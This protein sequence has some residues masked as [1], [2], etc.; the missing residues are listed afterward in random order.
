MWSP[1]RGAGAAHGTGMNPVPVN[2]APSAQLGELLLEHWCTCSSCSSWVSHLQVL[3]CSVN[4]QRLSFLLK[5][6][7]LMFSS[8]VDP[9][10]KSLPSPSKVLNNGLNKTV[11]FLQRNTVCVFFCFSFSFQIWMI[12][13]LSLEVLQFYMAF[14]GAPQSFSSAALRRCRLVPRC[15]P[16]HGHGQQCLCLHMWLSEDALG[17]TCRTQP[18]WAQCP[19]K[20]C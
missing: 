15:S 7:R 2:G 8:S 12:C 1:G 6:D 19:A 17:V 11:P 14:Q 20:S 9:F 13:S 10:I 18:S 3:Q 16:C 4:F 5:P